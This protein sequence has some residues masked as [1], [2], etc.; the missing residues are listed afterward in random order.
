M[1]WTPSTRSRS[2]GKRNRIRERWARRGSSPADLLNL[3]KPNGAWEKYDGLAFPWH[4]APRYLIRDR[5]RI[6]GDVALRLLG[7]AHLRGILR[8]YAWYYNKI[9]THLVSFSRD[10]GRTPSSLHPGL[11]LRYTQAA[12]AS[13]LRR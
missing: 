8:S 6:Y 4:E 7:E 1:A 9:R 12:S 10:P 13:S 3:W 5:D 2:P 11:G